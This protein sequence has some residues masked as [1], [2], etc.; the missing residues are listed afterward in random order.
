M[1]RPEPSRQQPCINV[2]DR[3]ASLRRIQPG[4]CLANGSGKTID[5]RSMWV[6]DIKVGRELPRLTQAT[7]DGA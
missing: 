7:E 6:G 3:I 1:D 5:Q 4:G 2:P